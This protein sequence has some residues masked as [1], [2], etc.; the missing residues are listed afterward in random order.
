MHL[1]AISNGIINRTFSLNS[2]A[3]KP[4]QICDSPSLHNF[5]NSIDESPRKDDGA[6]FL[7]FTF[8]LFAVLSVIYAAADPEVRHRHLRKKDQCHDKKGRRIRRTSRVHR[9]TS[10]QISGYNWKAEKAEWPGTVDVGVGRW[11]MLLCL[12]RPLWILLFS[13][14]VLCMDSQLGDIPRDPTETGAL[15][16]QKKKKNHVCSIS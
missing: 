6:R 5:W 12:L 10:W 7:S 16:S 8:C 13:G 9:S 15:R 1:N 3:P 14:L 11:L 4:C 2:H